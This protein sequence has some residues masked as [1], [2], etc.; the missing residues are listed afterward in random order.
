[1]IFPATATR[2]S[3]TNRKVT[4]LPCRTTFSLGY[5]PPNF[6]HYGRARA[7]VP[8]DGH[9]P[10]GQRGLGRRADART[11]HLRVSCDRLASPARS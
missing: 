1:M 2:R 4:A 10:A 7:N 9:E 3:G 5:V 6:F 11:R 8:H